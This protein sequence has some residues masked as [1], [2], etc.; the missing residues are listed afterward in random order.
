MIKR[1]D[2]IN[3]GLA[4][5]NQGKI[6]NVTLKALAEKLGVKSPSLYNHF[7]NRQE[8]LG[9]LA[10][11]SLENFYQWL[12]KGSFG[13]TGEK[14]LIALAESYRQ[15]A[16]TFPSQYQLV[17]QPS[18]WQEAE[19]VTCSNQMIA[20]VSTCLTDYHLTP[21][22]EIHFIRLLRSYLDGFTSFSVGQAFKLSADL[23]DSF[24]FGLQVIMTGLKKEVGTQ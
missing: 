15:F 9:I 6:D 7:A 3:A 1:D 17:Q 19:A 13:L 11:A 12:A 8:L 24:Y 14:K 4:L 2:I 5:L 20:L 21:E 18:Y 10:T 22:A 16:L 23:D